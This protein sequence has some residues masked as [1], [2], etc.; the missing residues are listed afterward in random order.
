[1]ALW[2][3]FSLIRMDLQDHS[4]TVHIDHFGPVAASATLL[5]YA[6]MGGV[7]ADVLVAALREGLVLLV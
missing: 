3:V 1:M 5:R 2:V 6:L 7:L 4:T